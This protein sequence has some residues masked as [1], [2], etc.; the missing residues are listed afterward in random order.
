MIKKS[1]FIFILF[2]LPVCVYGLNIKW[3]KQQNTDKIIFLFKNEVEFNAKREGA[4]LI[5]IKIPLKYWEKEPKPQKYLLKPSLNLV[6]SIRLSTSGIDIE[7]KSPAFGFVFYKIKNKVYLDVF[8]DELGK[9]W[10]KKEKKQKDK[11]SKKVSVQKEK[12]SNAQIPF[13]KEQKK[14]VKIK[15]EPKKEVKVQ[16]KEIIKESSSKEL[17]KKI[18]QKKEKKEKKVPAQGVIYKGSWLKAP[19]KQR[20]YDNP[21]YLFVLKSSAEKKIQ[22][23]IE[24]KKVEKKTSLKKQKEEKKKKEEPPDP[25]VQLYQARAAFINKDYE[26]AKS[27]YEALRAKKSL[28]PKIMIQVLYDLGDLY[29]QLYKDKLEDHYNDVVGILKEA[30]Y[31]DPDYYRVPELI[32]KLMWVNLKL[33]NLEEG[34]GYFNFLKKFYPKSKYIGVALFYLGDFYFKRKKYDKALKYLYES[35]DSYPTSKFIKQSSIELAITYDKLG[36]N[37]K[38]W[39]VIEYIQ[40][41]WFRY[42]LEDPDFL[43]LAA[44]IALKN[45]LYKEAKDFLWRYYNI[46]PKAKDLDIVLAHIGDCYLLLKKKKAA[47]KIYERVVKLFP[48]KEGA[49]IAKMRLAEEGIYDEFSIKSMFSIFDRPFNLRPVEVYKE[50]VQKHPKSPLAPLAQLKL[51]SWYIWRGKYSKALEEMVNFKKLFPKSDFLNKA[52]E[53]GKSAFAK[54]ILRLVKNG[55]YQEAVK[56]WNKYPFF[57][58]DIK[59]TNPEVPL[60]IALAMWKLGKIK[61]AILLADQTLKN[62]RKKK[63]FEDALNLL[64]TIYLETEKWDKIIE[65]Y[66][67]FSKKVTSPY[68]MEQ[69]KYAYALALEVEDK[70]SIDIW[71]SLLNSKNLTELQKGYVF[72]FVAKHSLKKENYEDVYDYSQQALA[73]FLE[74]DKKSNIDKIKD[75]FE[76]L[77]KVTKD[78][79]RL[80]E[81]IEWAER[82]KEYI[83]KSDLLEWTYYNY[84]LANLYKEAGYEDK[85][86]KILKELKDKYPNS[87][88][89]KLAALDLEGIGFRSKIKNIL[90]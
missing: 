41:R 74:K 82:E 43:K 16:K 8:K 42:Y 39:K 88:Y 31:Y 20:T 13:P 48:D 17:K 15:K 68:L 73:V 9:F 85:W 30:F 33:G 81:A 77:V 2:F 35:V 12:S 89:G 36:F 19:V 66:S 40:K 32:T 10:I 84:R 83:S 3:A 72:Y 56:V 55:I 4:T 34:M 65:L 57:Q 75:C 62:Q 79:G 61:K 29:I 44:S 78:S 53:L 26:T 76:M 54:E 11:S 67:K 14:E 80:L 90:K 87:Y 5:S 21:F 45:K 22:K 71:K 6:K 59:K 24:T 70:G 58:E 18:V 60:A 51:I 1:F 50:I 49:L 23:K 38:A 7:T 46:F 27:I 52:M 64:L 28:P 47:K 25:K 69:F 37:K 63:L 86:K